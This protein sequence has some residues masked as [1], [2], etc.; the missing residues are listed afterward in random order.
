MAPPS[1]ICAGKKILLVEDNPINAMLSRE[2]LRRR[3]FVVK[4]VASGELALT[5]V[6]G[7]CF[8]V[9]LTDLHM[10]GLDGFETTRRLRALEEKQ[11]L[12]RTPVVALTADA[13]QGIRE[14]CQDA[15][16]DGF[17]TKPIDPIE[18]DSVFEILFQPQ[19]T[20]AA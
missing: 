10:P 15:G 7:E 19:S 11:D 13:N 9:I 4:D 20:R 8:D 14:A 17:L 1:A 12:A 3:G 2:L 16:M 5:A 18:L 6:A